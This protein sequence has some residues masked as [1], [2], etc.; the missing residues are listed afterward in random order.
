MAFSLAK[1]DAICCAIDG[2][3]SL[4]KAA[5]AQSVGAST[6]LD[7]V[8]ARP[9][10]AEQYAR[11]RARGYALLADEIIAISDGDEGADSERVPRDKLRVDS[12]KWMLSK[13]LPKLYGDRLD[14]AATVTVKRDAAEMSDNELLLI[15][16]SKGANADA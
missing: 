4:R 11:A 6:F 9:D 5:K 3:A 10:L 16:L 2:G 7:W 12:R 8:D 1:A 15:A 13:M 14:L